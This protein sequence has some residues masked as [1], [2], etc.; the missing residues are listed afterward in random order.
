MVIGIASE[1]VAQDKSAGFGID[2]PAMAKIG[3][4]CNIDRAPV[5]DL[6]V[7]TGIDRTGLAAALG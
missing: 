4:V 2:D 7:R 1:V 5:S 3:S 6:F